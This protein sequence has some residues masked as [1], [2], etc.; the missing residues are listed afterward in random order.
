MKRDNALLVFFRCHDWVLGYKLRLC[1]WMY[2]GSRLGCVALCGDKIV[3]FVLLL[4]QC[5][6]LLVMNGN[7][8]GLC[9]NRVCFFSRS[10]R[11][12]EFFKCSFTSS[13]LRFKKSN[14]P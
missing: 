6:L 4:L 1:I 11:W 5:K 12:I 9:I 8:K 2:G 14:P 7:S 13:K 3:M 10:L